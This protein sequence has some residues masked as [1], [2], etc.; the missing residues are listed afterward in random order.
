MVRR[1]SPGNRL[2]QGLRHRVTPG[3]MLVMVAPLL[4]GVHS[5][6]GASAATGPR[7]P[8]AA[9]TFMRA[10]ESIQPDNVSRAHLD[11]ATAAFYRAWKT[12]YLVNG[13]G[14]HRYYV[15]VGAD[16]TARRGGS[17]SI[18]F[19]EGHGYGMIITALMAGVDPHAQTYF[20]GLYRFFKDHPSEVSPHLMAWNQ[21]RGCGNLPDDGADS[22]ADGDLD[23]AYALILADRQWGSAGPINY[24]Q[25][26]VQVIADPHLL[27]FV[28]AQLP[29]LA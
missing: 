19:S 2:A 11:E 29:V 27:E 5:P 25:E 3:C 16:R 1:T 22:A 14:A 20:D 4:G 24:L 8:F 10:A 23:V 17:A 9:H 21:V 18:S 7:H 6:R 12:R 15:F 28:A 26:A 13:C